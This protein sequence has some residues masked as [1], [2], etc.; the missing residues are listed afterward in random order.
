MSVDPLVSVVIP[1][2]NA[3]RWIGK[4]LESFARQTIKN[5]EVV[6]VDDGSKD[7]TATLAEAY[8]DSLDITVVRSEPNGA[9]ARPCNIGMRKAKGD[10]IVSCDADDMATPDRV[11]VMLKAWKLAGNKDC[12][13]F[14]DHCEVNE[15]GEVIT[16]SKL[17]EYPEVFKVRSDALAKDISIVQAE[18][19]FE[20]LLAG[21]FIRP[22]AVAFT[23]RV[24]QEVGG[25]DERLRNGQDY[26]L[27][28]RVAR[29]FPFVFVNR[30]LGLYRRS[31]GNISSR[32]IVDLAPS[33]IL[34][35]ERLLTLELS[36]TQ[37]RV[38]RTWIATNYQSLGYEF[39]NR[40][41]L[42]ES[43]QSYLCALRYQPRASA[44]RGMLVSSL[45]RLKP[46]Y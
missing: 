41:M 18:A 30:V 11:E 14:S 19:A 37:R 7:S 25:Y 21:C 5:I 15:A 22:C 34:A 31:A 6:V 39:G 40:K 27:Y 46:G 35:L 33:R 3:E 16:E 45:K 8:S 24:W 29:T 1:A 32:S 13:V 2:F 36:P 28:L 42:R 38:V 17:A 26:D 10:F 44:L 43:L 20:T 4:T 9:P 23:R 12:L